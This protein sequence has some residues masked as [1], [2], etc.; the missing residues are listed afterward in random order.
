MARLGAFDTSHLARALRAGDVGGAR[1]L[2]RRVYPVIDALL[3]E[4]F[5]QAVKAG[6]RL[7]G[8]PVGTPRE[9]LQ[10]LDAEGTE[11]LRVALA[12]LDG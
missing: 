10:E 2:W 4:P 1:A 9:P 7:R 5:S 11:R 8:L 12:R 3:E 6:L